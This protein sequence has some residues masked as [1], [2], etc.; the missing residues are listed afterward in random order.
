MDTLQLSSPLF[1][2]DNLRL[3]LVYDD[4]NAMRFAELFILF[5]CHTHTALSAPKNFK[6]PNVLILLHFSLV[7]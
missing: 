5:L 2:V 4:L 7:F 3:C 6:P 1:G